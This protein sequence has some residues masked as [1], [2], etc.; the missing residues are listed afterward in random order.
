MID[1]R[2]SRP[3]LNSE[4]YVSEQRHGSGAAKHLAWHGVKLDHP[5]WGDAS[6]SLAFTLHDYPG[7]ADM[8]V[9]V[10]AY[11]EPLE[12]ELPPLNR[13]LHWHRVVDTGL[14]SPADVSEP[15]D[16]PRVAGSAYPAESRSVVI[17]IAK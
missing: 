8:H 14:D 16:E 4:I 2:H 10:N 13:G 3:S 1:F 5:D 7:D 11:W 6:R 17:L 12:F 15:V 9:I